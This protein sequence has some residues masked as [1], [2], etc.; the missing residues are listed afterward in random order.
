M[1]NI[2]IDNKIIGVKYE[3]VRFSKTKLCDG[4]SKKCINVVYASNGVGKSSTAQIIQSKY[5]N[6]V[7]TLNLFNPNLISSI[8]VNQDDYGIVNS[9]RYDRAFA[10]DSVS[11]YEGKLIIAPNTAKELGAISEATKQLKNGLVNSYKKTN[12][13]KDKI[14]IKYDT[15]LKGTKLEKFCLKSLNKN[16]A[17]ILYEQLKNILEENIECGELEV[18][19]LIEYGLIF[20][21]NLLKELEQFNDE[22]SNEVSNEFPEINNKDYEFYRSLLNYMSNNE[23]LIN[24]ICLMCGK[25]VLDEEIVTTR[26]KIIKN[27]IDNYLNTKN[28]N[29]LLTLIDEFT[30]HS[31]TSKSLISAQKLA[32]KITSKNISEMVVKI[33]DIFAKF[34]IESIRINYENCILKKIMKNNNIFSDVSLIKNNEVKVDNLS[35]KNKSKISDTVKNKFMTSLKNLGFKY[36][37]NTTISI[38]DA[39]NSLVLKI[40]NLSVEELYNNILSESEKTLL[41]L[42]LFLAISNGESNTMLLIDDPIDSHDEKTKWFITNQIIEFYKN[43]DVLLIIFTHDLS[44]SKTISRISDLPQK[45]LVMSSS[46]IVE[47]ENPSLFF[48]NIYDYIFDVQ[49]EIKTLSQNAKYFI[50]LAFFMRYLS[51][52]QKKLYSEFVMHSLTSTPTIPLV[53]MLR[54]DVKEIGFNLLSNLF[55]HYN[56]HFDSQDL[57]NKIS[58]F[59]ITEYNDS[60]LPPYFLTN[61]SSEVLIYELI[62]DIGIGT[63]YDKE[64]VTILYSLLIRNII[65]K[66]FL[67]GSPRAGRISLRQIANNY[68]SANGED[69]LYR[70]YILNKTLVD[71]FAHIEAG[72]DVLLT[73]DYTYVVGKYNEIL[74]L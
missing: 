10:I 5:D 53:G 29:K 48:Q 13:F 6:D 66:K 45:C 14:L 32:R 27:I 23:D 47:V 34:D 16:H 21:I 39:T 37:D 30:K 74:L 28:G 31:F 17:D 26:I 38:D 57:L 15:F 58:S 64:I 8:D 9:F 43:S 56:G 68:K 54:R 73:Y 40:R 69:D 11:L 62:C 4:V 41:S 61:A 19:E 67:G 12:I 59:M 65:E 44:F 55:V 1:Y 60:V 3:N 35:K 42:S 33:L 18:N 25:T 52:F 22:I 50:P 20:D 51:K 2:S 24:K 72:I 49:N 46:E 63:Q 70:F 71:D 7:K 36:C